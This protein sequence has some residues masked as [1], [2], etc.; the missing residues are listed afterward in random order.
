MSLDFSSEELRKL[1]YKSSDMVV[2]LFKG[3]EDRKVFHNK[4]PK[5]V[6][7]LFKEGL[8]ENPSDISALLDKINSDVIET[9]TF[10]GS[11]NYHAYC[12]GGAAQTGIIADLI[13]SALNQ[14]NTKWHGGSSATELEK[15]VINWIAEFIGYPTSCGGTLVSGGSVANLTS[16]AVARK[17]KY[18]EDIQLEGLYGVK[19]AT[20]YTSSQNHSCVDKSVDILGIGRKH[21]RKIPVKDD[22]RMD[23]LKLEEQIIKDIEA[24]FL[25]ICVIGTAGTTNTCAVDPLDEI[26]DICKKYNLWFHVD[27]AYGAPAAGVKNYKELFKGIERADSIAVDAH[28]WFYVPYEA[29]GVLVK[30]P[31]H[32]RETFK[33]LGDYVKLDNEASDRFEFMEYG[34]QLSRSFK[35]LKVWLLFKTF[36]AE[37]V[38]K[39]IENDI[40]NTH[41]F[42]LLINE[43]KDFE[44]MAPSPLSA[45][46][47]RYLTTDEGIRNNEEFIAKLNK[48]ILQEA[49]KDGRVFITG[50]IIDGKPVLRASFLNFRTKKEHV[51][52]LLS[53]IREIGKRVSKELKKEKSLV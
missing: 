23:T 19:K 43:A 12:N 52:Y 29:G 53:V 3:L 10:L 30:N 5:E 6:E 47:F 35:A 7:S 40:N 13:T 39:A 32:L 1:L 28:K 44:Q 50:T 11:P 25:P 4:T 14:N 9:S 15:N 42:S 2:D 41:Y 33:I 34:L 46:C 38:R 16:L 48:K 51:D 8:P 24:G 37:K 21:L 20:L 31:E 22:F 18:S 49:E 45:V 26:A 36:G 27:G 17:V